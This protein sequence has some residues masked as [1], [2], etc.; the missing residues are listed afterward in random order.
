M[1]ITAPLLFGRRHVTPVVSAFLAAHPALRVELT[2]ND[3]NVNLVGDGIDL[4]VRIGRLDDSTLVRRQVGVVRRLTIAAPAYLARRGEPTAP[5]A[6]AAHDVI[7]VPNRDGIPEWRFHAAGSRRETLV[8]VAP[9]FTVNEN[10]AMLSAVRAGH[11]IGR[12]LSYQVADDLAAG[13]LVRV[14][15]PFEPPPLP[16]QLVIAGGPHVQARVRAF[17]DHAA[18]RLSRICAKVEA[19]CGH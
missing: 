13:R 2:L 4:A 8:R 7:L 10:D 9:R 12:A 17:L 18:P 1:R 15:G 19:Q 11:G 5:R 16:V 3:R 6:L 14:L